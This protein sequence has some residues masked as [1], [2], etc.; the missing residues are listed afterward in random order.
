M[1]MTVSELPEPTLQFFA[2][3]HLPQY[4]Q[5]TSREFCDLAQWVIKNLPANEQRHLALQ[6]LLEAKDCAVRAK[7]MG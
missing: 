3:T 2:Y 4:L 6:R 5:E 7:V 1:D